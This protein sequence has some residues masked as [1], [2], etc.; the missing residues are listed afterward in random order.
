MSSSFTWAHR[1]F[2]VSDNK[3][4]EDQRMVE[5][6]IVPSSI[7]SQFLPPSSSVV[8]PH[9]TSQP[10]SAAPESSFPFTDPFYIAQCEAAQNCNPRSHSAFSQSG[11]PSQQST[12]VVQGPFLRR[13]DIHAPLPPFTGYPFMFCDDIS[14]FQPLG[15][16]ADGG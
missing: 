13:C 8:V 11:L 10:S 5:D 9:F 4:D 2:A 6:L 1:Q 3:V 7:T 14:R 16:V 15:K 12:F